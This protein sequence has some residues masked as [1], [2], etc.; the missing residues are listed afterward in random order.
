MGGKG[1][2]DNP[3]LDAIE[4]FAPQGIRRV[5]EHGL[6][7]GHD[8]ERQDLFFLL[9]DDLRQAIENPQTVLGIG[10][11][12]GIGLLG[13]NTGGLLPGLGDDLVSG[14]K[15]A[16]EFKISREN[17]EYSG[18]KELSTFSKKIFKII[19]KN[20]LNYDH[21]NRFNDSL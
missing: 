21:I 18:P 2:I 3:V 19:K 9:I 4:D 20:Q 8:L 16:M 6:H 10:H 5:I 14:N 17:G 12:L 13:G 15:K 11:R 1:H 7:D